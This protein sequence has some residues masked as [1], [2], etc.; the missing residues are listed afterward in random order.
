MAAPDA[1]HAGTAFHR[2]SG[3]VSA[4]LPTRL[5]LGGGPRL[6]LLDG[7]GKPVG[8]SVSAMLRSD[9][10]FARLRTRIDPR[11]PPG[12]YTAE[13]AGDQGK[14]R[15]EIVVKPQVALRADPPML[16]IEG[17]GGGRCTATIMLANAG[18]VAAELPAVAAFGIFPR[19]GVETAIGKA[20][21]SDADDGLQTLSRFIE[22]LRGN[23]GGLVRVKLEAGEPIAPGAAR[24]VAVTLDLPDRLEAGRRYSGIWP[25]L[26]LNYA[27]RIVAGRGGEVAPKGG[28]T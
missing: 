3:R 8:E 5:E 28:R 23:Y 19:N 27:V 2:G 18:N 13:L 12:S 16:E 17:A 4:I 26:N 24:A 14:C 10:D 11:L 25:L 7:A 20:Y 1:E 9:G 6:Q 22:G 15:I 21:R